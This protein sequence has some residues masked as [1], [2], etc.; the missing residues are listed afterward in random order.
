MVARERRRSRWSKEQS[1]ERA[2]W[3]VVQ[4]VVEIVDEAASRAMA[5]DAVHP[6]GD[7]TED[8]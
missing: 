2:A 7:A 4:A 3:V 6:L 5:K 8:R 1:R